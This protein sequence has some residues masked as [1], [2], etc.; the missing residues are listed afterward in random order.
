MGRAGGVRR[1]H[2]ARRHAHLLPERLPK[3]E[4][5]HCDLLEDQFQLTQ[6][7]GLDRPAGG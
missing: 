6:V 5:R 4:R 7:V 2:L 1:A 3:R